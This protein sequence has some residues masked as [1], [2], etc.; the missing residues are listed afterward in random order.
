MSYSIQYYN[1][2]P[3]T[4]IG[5]FDK[6][7]TD[8]LNVKNIKGDYAEFDDL[9][10][11][12]NITTLNLQVNNNTNLNNANINN[13]TCLNDANFINDINVNKN[14]N[15][16]L[17]IFCRDINASRNANISNTL[18][19]NNIINNQ[20]IT[21]DTITSNNITN[22][23]NITT[24]TISSN[25]ITNSQNI[26]TD[27][28]SSNNITNNNNITTDTLSSNNITNNNTITSKDL[29]LRNNINY[30]NEFKNNRLLIV[31]NYFS[32][33]SDLTD[34]N[35]YYLCISSN[36]IYTQNHIYKLLTLSPLTTQ[37]IE[38]EDFLLIYVI[39]DKRYLIY[40]NNKWMCI[41]EGRFNISNIKNNSLIFNDYN[42]NV[43][44]GQYSNVFGYNNKLNN[45]TAKYILV[46]G[47]NHNITGNT[48]SS[49]ITGYNNSVS[50]SSYNCLI[51]GSSNFLNGYCDNAIIGGYN[52]KNNSNTSSNSLLIGSNNITN[53]CSNSLIC[54]GNS[55]IVKSKYSLICGS[56][57]L[58]NNSDKNYNIISGFGN[59]INN[60]Y[61][62]LSGFYNNSS[63]NYQTILG[64][65]SDNTN[66]NNLFVIGNG[67][68]NNNRSNALL[69]N[70][71]G[72]LTI[73]NLSYSND[74]K[75][76]R[77]LIIDDYFK[78]DNTSPLIT[79][80][81][82]YL[83][84]Y[85]YS[86]YTKNKIYYTTSLSPLTTTEI[87][88]EQFL[89]INVVSNNYFFI[90]YNNNWT[91]LSIGQNK[92]D[93]V[94]NSGEI[95]NDYSNNKASGLYSHCEGSNN[96]ALD[97]Y[98]HSEGY[99]TVAGRS[100]SHSEGYYTTA[101]AENSHSEGYYT[102]ASGENSHSSGY[103]T[104]ADIN[105]Q[106]VCGTFNTLNN[107][108]SL[109]CV[110][111]GDTNTRSDAFVVKK[112]EVKINTNQ[113]RNGN[114]NIC[115]LNLSPNCKMFCV[116]GLLTIGQNLDWELQSTYNVNAVF[117]GYQI[118]DYNMTV[119]TNIRTF[120]ILELFF[121]YWALIYSFSY[122]DKDGYQK[123][124]YFC[125]GGDVGT[126]KIGNNKLYNDFCGKW[127]GLERNTTTVR[128][129]S[130]TNLDGSLIY[131]YD[132]QN[133]HNSQVNPGY[134]LFQNGNVFSWPL[135][136]N[137]I[138]S[139]ENFVCFQKTFQEIKV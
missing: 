107:S 52:N 119:F 110:G 41:N 40:Y 45:G 29:T 88:P 128:P 25:N 97:A 5:R 1:N 37:E 27:T 59:E 35:Y 78:G 65:Y 12:N 56:N 6:I 39:Y 132:T 64:K 134:Y 13:L 129:Q 57:H 79:N 46:N 127:Y 17:D 93:Y 32:S 73:N 123:T 137:I 76:S 106:F 118:S 68:D 80:N 86:S 53:G 42:N 121:N 11:N 62:L 50:S 111:N 19:S 10:I 30:N 116:V 84:I 44:L 109:F 133:G 38:L 21:T 77:V 69:L 117:Y 100:C 60:S 112:D 70:N 131:M 120:S 115:W 89:I 130:R 98:S 67:T 8:D 51:F 75:N 47:Y 48:Q 9:K 124:F 95:F 2:Y 22:N 90:Y 23:N 66:T 108:N 139:I 72:D 104:V 14:I 101:G 113:Q 94:L 96:E 26:T 54:G 36:G 105:N 61:C 138:L 7:I 15:C 125:N 114:Y 92:L 3:I 16:D 28:L 136:K 49:I 87:N 74:Y 91:N 85:T 99:H 33:T 58:S 103:Y 20:N 71:S 63:N 31:N 18:N 4:L 34:E 82:Y 126:I 122:R 135:N 24:D 43:N 81:K 102:T 83:C 55:N